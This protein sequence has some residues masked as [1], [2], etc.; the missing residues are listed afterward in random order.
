MNQD[1]VTKWNA[2]IAEND[3]VY[4]LGDISMAIRPVELLIGKLNGKKYLISG[5]HDFTHTSHKKSNS[6]QKQKQMIDLYTSYGWEV[7]S[8]QFVL[9]IK[10][11]NL[12]MLLC[13]LPYSDENNIY[14]KGKRFEKMHPEDNGLPLLCGHVHQ[15]WKIK[16]STKGTLM[17]NVGVDVNDMG[18]ISLDSIL[19]IINT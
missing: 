18:P 7:L 13:H 9:K 5:N 1:L 15:N 19:E 14:S 4:H 12:T 3:V 2:S 17:I 16:R 8:D 11:L 6:L 10:E